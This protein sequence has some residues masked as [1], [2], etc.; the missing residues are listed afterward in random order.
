M[1]VIRRWALCALLI[2]AAASA[3]AQDEIVLGSPPAAAP[4]EVVRVPV[5]LRDAPGTP[6]GT[7]GAP[8]QWIDL[9]ITNSH[10][11]FIAGCLGTTYP[12]CELG[13]EPAGVLA[14]TPETSGT[15]INIASLYVRRIFG[16]P[17]SFTGE[18]D[19]IGY[20]TFRL[21]PDVA[22]TDTAIRLHLE[23][24]KTFLSNHDKTI[25]ENT[26]LTLTDAVVTVSL[27]PDPP[28]APTFDFL[29]PASGCNAAA[30]ICRVGEDILFT[31][32]NPI[33]PCDT[34][35]W[36]FGDGATAT[37]VT[38]V[39]HRFTIPDPN[40]VAYALYTVTAIA[41]RAGGSESYMDFVLILP[42]CSVVTVPETGMAGT[43]VTFTAD[44][45]PPGLAA[46]VSWKFGDGTT[47][48]GNP[49]QHTYQFGDTYLWEATVVTPQSQIPCIV[50]R[51]IQVSGP[52][53]P[54][55]RPY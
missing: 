37:N 38:S 1:N 10:P 40:E 44:T 30:P 55:R 3:L 17:L 54:R 52:P 20:I 29:G 18:L 45:V 25:V 51:P 21:D 22:K 31:V 35:T 39:R 41:T 15:L 16:G 9:S 43:P 49:V 26:E 19:L 34:L 23:P 28:V 13:F 47:G 53:A 32:L 14:A 48:V 36:T 2:T 5:F 7:G 6:L 33:D 8:I 4:G 27:C 50:R 12:N 11:H 46:A 24:G 42:A